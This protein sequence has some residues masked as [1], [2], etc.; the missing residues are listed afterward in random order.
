MSGVTPCLWFFGDDIEEV[1]AIN[2]GPADRWGITWQIVPKQLGE[3]L[4]DPDPDKAGRTM[5]AML[6][7]AKLDVAALRAAH[8]GV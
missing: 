3:L 8:D 5:T 7:M 2:G 6:A 4:S 1:M